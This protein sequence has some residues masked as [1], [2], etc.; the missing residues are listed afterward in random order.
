MMYKIFIV[1]D[2]NTIATLLCRHLAN[3]GYDAR[4]AADF[5][6][7]LTE[8]REFA[9]DLVILDISLP[10]FNG[11]YWCS[12]IRKVSQAPIIFLSSHTENMD[13]VMAMNMGGDDY[14]TKPFALDIVVAKIQALLRRSYDFSSEPET[15]EARGLILDL[16]STAVSY[17]P[18][19]DELTKN[20]FRMLRLLFLNKNKVVSREDLMKAL[21]DSDCFVDDNTLT[22]NVNR[23]RKKL[24]ALGAPADLIETKKGLGYIV[25]TDEDK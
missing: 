17:G 14:L 3:W 21:W 13:I 7:I 9:P 8:F 12:E 23:L 6:D 15:V 22:V 2:D 16:N 24:E 10:F 5:H 4:I 18:N 1:E 20:E 11:Y 19:R 25:V